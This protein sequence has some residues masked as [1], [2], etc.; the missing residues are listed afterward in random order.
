[1]KE[2]LISYWKELVSILIAVATL[3]LCI[4]RKKGKEDP[5]GEFMYSHIPTFIRE[6]ESKIGAGKG[7]TKK[8]LV[9]SIIAKYY[10]DITGFDLVEG[11]YLYDDYSRFVELILTT[12]Q[13]KEV[14]KSEK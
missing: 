5:V 8:M 9:M 6:I 13:K 2:F 7:D 3:L 12:P 14:K 11:S 4:F 1:M 10:K